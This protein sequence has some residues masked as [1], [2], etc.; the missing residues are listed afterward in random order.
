MT[1][2][3]Q[4]LS[5]AFRQSPPNALELS[6]AEQAKPYHIPEGGMG[7]YAIDAAMRALKVTD[8]EKWDII[9]RAQINGEDVDIPA[10]LRGEI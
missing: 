8:R 5:D 10:I 4:A 2:N 1:D 6:L 9:R 7:T 3:I